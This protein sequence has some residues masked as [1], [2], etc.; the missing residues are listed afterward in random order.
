[1]ADEGSHTDLPAVTETVSCT[2]GTEPALVSQW[3]KVRER[4]RVEVGDVEYR[5]WLQQI[6]LG[7]LEED[8][9]TLFLPT[10][11]LRD[12]VR[13]RY[14]DRLQELWR[15]E[16]RAVHHVELQV[17]RVSDAV[18]APVAVET[19]AA[20]EIEAPA[21]QA[22]AVQ[23]A[24]H[25]LAAP[26]DPRFTFDS[27]VVGKPNEFAYACARRVAEKPSSPGFNPLFLYGASVWA[28]PISC[29]PSGPS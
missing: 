28:R 10:R 23:D 15:N 11:F 21:V 13:G 17:K 2:S 1:M 12:W 27:F 16:N 6:V 18:T 25:D 14:G 4:L 24:R 22:S 26:L 5:T 3:V 9:I 7:P 8:E 29:T 20:I 19:A